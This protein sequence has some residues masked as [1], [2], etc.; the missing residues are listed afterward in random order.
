MKRAAVAAVVLL[1]ACKP[2]LTAEELLDPEACAEC[3][4][5]HYRQWSGSMHAYA[6]DDPV[7]LAMNQRGQEETD[8]ALGDFCIRCHAPMALELGETTDGTNAADLPQ[9][10]KGVTCAFCHRTEDVTEDHNNGLVMS[11]DDGLM[12]GGIDDP[13]ATH[14]HDSA[15]SPLH[16]RL[17]GDSASLCGSC[18]DVV[19]PAGVHLERTFEEWRGSVFSHEGLSQLTCGNCH[20]RGYDGPAFTGEGA[21][22]RRVHEHQMVGVDVAITDWPERDEQLQ[23][24]QEDLDT[25]LYASMCV[26]P[27]DGL[28]DVEVTLENVA[29]GHAFPSGTAQ[30]RRVWV[31][32]RAWA[33]DTEVLSSGVVADGEPLT[34]LVDP[35]LW[36][37]GDR[38]LDEDGQEV[39]MFWDAVEVDSDLLPASTTLDPTDPDYI[40]WVQRTYPIVTLPPT[41]VE[42][43][44]RMR[45]IGLDVMQ[46]LVDS[47]HL[48]A[49]YLAEIPTFDLAATVLTW[50]GDLGS[51]VP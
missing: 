21:P 23:M 47:G 48:D 38:I 13:V 35:F 42:M 51:C 44:V 4:A 39:H 12:R 26:R 50:D 8:G 16:D 17:Q 14:A 25:T 18:H 15:Y 45:P 6:A 33:D 19:T 27:S 5:E 10:L 20:M 11:S 32:V 34:D 24:V 31:E 41:R 9:H 40:H 46:S 29:A 49:A 2:P 3:H 22:T 28:F 43:R 7:F 30:D 37:I 1:A 36:R